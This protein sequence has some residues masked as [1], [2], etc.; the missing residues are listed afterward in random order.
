MQLGM[1][2]LGKMGANLSRRLIKAGDEVVGFSHR[3]VA[4]MR[5]QFGGHAVK[6]TDPHEPG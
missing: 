2:G 4:A 6:K 5:N 3:L 1:I